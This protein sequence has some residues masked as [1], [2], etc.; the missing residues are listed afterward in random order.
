VS[1]GAI[2]SPQLL[3]LSG[4]GP[5]EHL[6]ELGIPVVAELPVGENL[7]D[8]QM[9]IFRNKINKPLSR[10]LGWRGNWWYDLQYSLLGTGPKAATGTEVIVHGQHEK[11]MIGKVHP[12][13]YAVFGSF[14]LDGNFFNFNEQV[15]KEYLDF[16]KSYPYCV[17]TFLVLS[18]PQSKGTIKLK[19]SDPFDYPSIDVNYFSEKV[20]MDTMIRS[21]RFWEQFMAT[22]TMK[23]LGVEI[24]DMRMSF[25]SQHKFRSD[26]YW[27]CMIRHVALTAYHHAGTCKMGAATDPTAVVDPQ[28]RV[29]G[30]EGLRVAD[31]SI[32]PNITS[33][34]T[35]IPTIM[36]A[37]KAA[38]MILSANSV[39]KI[40]T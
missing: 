24:D 29:R 32:F 18:R 11:S 26:E 27:E 36:V 12:D 33:G 8:H 34:N 13:F 1:A 38:D 25:C 3:M 5:K 23:E 39:K 14:A 28:L 19:S 10:D 22:K 30:I 35:N 16:A 20:D 9:L 21:T 40:K 37:E 15:A 7:Q 6:T 17:S 2:N 31:A 4:I